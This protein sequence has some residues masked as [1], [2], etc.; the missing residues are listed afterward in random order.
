MLGLL[1][2]GDVEEW[3]SSGRII[4]SL[5]GVIEESIYRVRAVGRFMEDV[6]KKY[7]GE[8]STGATNKTKVSNWEPNY[9]LVTAH[10]NNKNWQFQASYAEE[11]KKKE[12]VSYFDGTLR[13]RQ[14]VTK[15]NSDDNAIVGEV[16]YDNQGRPAIEVL[17]VPATENYISYYRDFN[18]NSTNSAAYSHV[19]FDWSLISENGESIDDTCNNATEGM[20]N[21]SGASKYYGP[22]PIASNTF[23]DYVPDAKKYPFSQIEYTSDNTGRIRRKSGVGVTH[24]LGS[25]HEMK[26]YYGTPEQEELIRLFGNSVGNAL[27]YKK[28]VVIDPNGQVSISFIDPQGRT[29]ATALAAGSPLSLE[30]LD[31][32]GNETLHKRFTLDL[33]NRNQKEASDLYPGIYDALVAGKEIIV[34]GDG[35]DYFFEYSVDEDISFELECNPGYYYPFV[36]DLSV[37]LTDDCGEEQLL[38]EINTTAGTE[39]LSGNDLA[40]T[41][42]DEAKTASARLNT[43]AYTFNKVLQIDHE[44]LDRYAS[45]YRNK[46]QDPLN[47]CYVDPS[48]FAPSAVF[49]SCYTTCEECV[50]GLGTKE[51]YVIDELKGRFI[52]PTFEQEGVDTEGFMTVTWSDSDLDVNGTESIESAEVSALIKTFSREWELIKQACE[53]P[54]NAIYNEASC[55]V[56]NTTLLQDMKPL[57]QYGSVDFTTVLDENG[58]PVKDE[59]N[60]EITAIQDPLSVFNENNQL[61]LEDGISVSWRTPAKPYQDA[62]GTQ[63]EIVVV[64]NEDGSYTPAVRDITD[65]RNGTTDSGAE[66]EW[67]VPENLA[68]VQDFLN[69]W[70]ANWAESLLAYHPENCYLDYATALCNVKDDVAIY[71]VI[72]GQNTTV[73]LDSDGFDS[74]IREINVFSQA[75]D[76]GLLSANDKALMELDPYFEKQIGAR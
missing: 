67:I 70:R 7:Y 76:Y 36:Y 49:N 53:A 20:G 41:T 29:I 22:Q 9:H 8:W 37:S 57:G 64:Q 62:L 72:S 42:P 50:E 39:D 59:N 2:S 28:N 1:G 34:T 3:S 45:D 60:N 26:Y 48:Q 40:V 35:V 12:V 24:K 19:D 54:C 55:E 51:A 23:Q 69:E 15:I 47:D 10:E 4:E 27:H 68:D 14:T 33:S 43:G 52:N 65:V 6:T 66:Y 16:I 56:S 71:D 5:G 21:N 30:G 61:V 46:L 75:K 13:N 63:S 44:V 31:D 17:P 73:I 18:K 11:G 74:Y 58:T 38:T 32:E 25:G